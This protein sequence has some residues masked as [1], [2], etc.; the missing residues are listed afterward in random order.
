MVLGRVP[1]ERGTI[2]TGGRRRKN[3]PLFTVICCSSRHPKL[4]R[5]Y[6]VETGIT[7]NLKPSVG[8][9]PSLCKKPIGRKWERLLQYDLGG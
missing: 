8:M 5:R 7:L 4:G 6:D 2:S 1:A 3:L 9:H